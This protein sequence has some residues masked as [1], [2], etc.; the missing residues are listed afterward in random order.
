VAILDKE[1]TITV[2]KRQIRY[3]EKL[4]YVL[5][6]NSN[7]RYVQPMILTIKFKDLPVYSKFKVN[8]EC[9]FC[10]KLEQKEIRN[11]DRQSSLTGYKLTGKV[12]CQPCSQKM[13]AETQI[14]AIRPTIKGK[15]NIRY[16]HGS[17]GY[18]SYFSVAKKKNLP[19]L[20]TIDEFIEITNK[21]CHY[22][23]I[24]KGREYSDKNMKNGID[25]IIPEKGYILENCLPCCYICNKMKLDNSYNDFLNKIKDIYTNMKLNENKI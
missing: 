6:K 22:C 5:E 14:G 10:G 24:V 12:R 4:G 8:V 1:I 19:F 15:K 20:L 18:K 13:A 9:D 7:N 17:I 3:Y 11:L 16:V 2:N 25:K 23:G 21:P